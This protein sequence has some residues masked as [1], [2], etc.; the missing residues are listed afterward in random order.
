MTQGKRIY[1]PKLALRAAFA[2]LALSPATLALLALS[3]A[4]LAAQERYALGRVVVEGGLPVADVREHVLMSRTFDDACR[5]V[6]MRLQPHHAALAGTLSSTVE[7]AVSVFGCRTSAEPEVE[8]SWKIARSPWQDASC[9]A[10]AG[11]ASSGAAS[12]RGWRATMALD[13]PAE[14][15]VYDLALSCRITGSGTTDDDGMVRQVYVTYA[16]PLAAFSPPQTSWYEKAAC[17]GAGLTA[18]SPEADVLRA[19]LD[20]LYRHG[21]ASWLYGFANKID[22]GVYH[23]PLAAEKSGTK[24]VEYRLDADEI[25]L[26]CYGGSPPYCQCPW[27]ALVA[28]DALCD[29]ASCYRFSETFQ[30]IA[31][32]MGVGGLRAVVIKGAVGAG[33]VTIPARSLDP[34]FPRNVRCG[35]SAEECLPYYFSSH[36]LRARD[37][38]LYDATFGRTYE[39]PSEPVALSRA[40]SIGRVMTF[41]EAPRHH[42]YSL[43]EGYGTWPFYLRLPPGELSSP[44]A[45]APEIVGRSVVFTGDVEF[46]TSPSSSARPI[47]TLSAQVG[48]EILEVGDYVV[49]GALFK[50]GK[51]ITMR[52]SWDSARPTAGVAAGPPG[53]YQVELTFSGEAV[54]RSRTDGPYELRANFTGLAEELRPLTAR[55]LAYGFQDFG[56][57]PAQLDGFAAAG[58]DGDGDG[59]FDELAITVSLTV[60]EPQTYAV[61]A[62]L[63]QGTSTVAYAGAKESLDEGSPTVR[64]EIPGELIARES[65]PA[66]PYNL[67]LVLYDGDSIEIDSLQQPIGGLAPA[68]FR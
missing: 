41:L 57:D 26:T 60:W 43:R 36:S 67:T 39:T 53:E 46:S 8:C 50:D 48:V 37:G 12:W 6:P 40:T 19:I 68:S 16:S 9:R 4:A 61:E 30:A 42:L 45:T 23:F 47:G 21:G 22:A 1:G 13:L 28:A 66:A 58:V 5:T 59:F 35:T 44:H 62:R 63:A 15:G 20:G 55:T 49:Q 3:P 2:L 10:A 56:E 38:L 51:L 25:E 32:V 52:S 24:R 34:R 14:T 29:F 11:G 17:W 31:G 64:L 27:Q 65:D 7:L 33:F 54:R 18:E